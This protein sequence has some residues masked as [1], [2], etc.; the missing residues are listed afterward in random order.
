MLLSLLGVETNTL[1]GKTRRVTST[2]VQ[3]I[4]IVVEAHRLQ[5]ICSVKNAT[6]WRLATDYIRN[7]MSS[8]LCSSILNCSASTS[9]A[10]REPYRT[11]RDEN[12][13][14]TWFPEFYNLSTNSSSL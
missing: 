6:S 11:I 13:E 10:Q 12:N 1:T 2:R 5:Y 9:P 7:H 14:T 4:L 8:H 3:A